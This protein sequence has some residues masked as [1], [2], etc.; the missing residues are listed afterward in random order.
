MVFLSE[1]INEQYLTNNLSKGDVLIWEGYIFEDGNCKDS[2]FLVLSECEDGNFLAVRAT[3]KT[4]FYEKL[5]VSLYREFIVIPKDQES[6]LPEKTI[7]D[8]NLVKCFTIDEIKKL[9]GENI[10]KKE[11][12]SEKLICE[13]NNRVRFS[14]TIEKNIKNRILKY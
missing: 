2:R 11:R 10:R 14:K 9:F 8:F 6:S 5:K 7:I 4:N 3:T 1:E 13:I 12:I